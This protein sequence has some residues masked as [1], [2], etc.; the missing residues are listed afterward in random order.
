MQR[1]TDKINFGGN[2]RLAGCWEWTAH[3]DRRG[4]GQFRLDD[5]IQKAHRV[6]YELFVGPIPDG[7]HVRHKCDNRGCVNPNHLETGTHEDNMRDMA[8]R[9]R[10]ARLNGE[11]NG[12][13]KLTENDVRVIREEYAS[14]TVTQAELAEDYGVDPSV[15]GKIVNNK[16]WTHVASEDNEKED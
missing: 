4:Y 3:K 13:S 12:M 5:R 9:G 15:I 16:I 8:G 6:S 10:V 11:S 2:P 7:L 1:F 14:G